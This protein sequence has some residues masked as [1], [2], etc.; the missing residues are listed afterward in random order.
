MRQLRLFA[1]AGGFLVGVACAVPAQASE[2]GTPRMGVPGGTLAAPDAPAPCRSGPQPLQLHPPP[3][4][5]KN[6]KKQ[7]I[8]DFEYSHTT[9]EGNTFTE[10]GNVPG[11]RH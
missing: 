9:I 1:I 6:A 5:P 3:P 4:K 11:I 8:H 7:P 10:F 2:C